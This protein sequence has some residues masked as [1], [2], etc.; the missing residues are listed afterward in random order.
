MR[1][2]ELEAFRSPVDKGAQQ[3]GVPIPPFDKTES[4]YDFVGSS[5]TLNDHALDG[6]DKATLVPLGG[7]RMPYITQPTKTWV[8]GTHTIYTYQQDGDREMFWMGKTEEYANLLYMDFHVR[9]KVKV[10][11]GVVNTTEDYTFL[12]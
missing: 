2:G 1:S 9:T 5:Y 12:P 6:E 4:M 8:I 11:K 3:T 10:P 7:G